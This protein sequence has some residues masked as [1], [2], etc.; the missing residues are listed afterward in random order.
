MAH[1]INSLTCPMIKKWLLMMTIQSN[2]GYVYVMS[3]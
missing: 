2:G 3:G 1:V